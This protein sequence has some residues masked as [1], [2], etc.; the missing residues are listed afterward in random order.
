MEVTYGKVV[1]FLLKIEV[2][3]S[4]F[5]ILVDDWVQNMVQQ[6][7]YDQLSAFK[8]WNQSNFIEK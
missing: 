2:P 8:V 3:A 1:D 7:Q 4:F 6:F 5:D